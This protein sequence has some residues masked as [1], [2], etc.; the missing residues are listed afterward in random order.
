MSFF[1]CWYEMQEGVGQG[2]GVGGM[3]SEPFYNGQV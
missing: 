2:G 3:S 1:A